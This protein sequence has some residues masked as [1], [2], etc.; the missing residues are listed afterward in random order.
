L[1]PVALGVSDLESKNVLKIVL[2]RIPTGRPRGK[3]KLEPRLID[4]LDVRGYAKEL[5]LDA[6]DANGVVDSK[7]VAP[8]SEYRPRNAK[9]TG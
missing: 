6:C 5:F 2:D 3:R 9:T 1:K 8:L 7:G 4:V